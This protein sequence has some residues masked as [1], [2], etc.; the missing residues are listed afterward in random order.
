MKEELAALKQH[1]TWDLL[2]RSP[3]MNVVGS[4]WVY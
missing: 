4:K 1:L 3:D 2:P